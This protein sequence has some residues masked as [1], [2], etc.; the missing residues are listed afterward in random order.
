VQQNVI[1][2][3]QMA[4]YPSTIGPDISHVIHGVLDVGQV[5]FSPKIDKNSFLTRK[6]Q[7]FGD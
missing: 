7:R 5:N 4:R 3:D 1:D 6:P 2:N